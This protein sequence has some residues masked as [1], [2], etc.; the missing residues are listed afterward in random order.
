MINFHDIEQVATKLGT[1]ANAERVIL[2][3]S[4]ARGD[5]REHS[6]VDFMIVAE[7][8]LPRFK[9]SRELYKML[10]PHPF[11]MDIV[12]YTPEEIERGKRTPVSFVSS[13]LQE[14]K[15]LYDR[16]T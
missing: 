7:S 2:F 9:R 10:R 12:V 1:A 14:G 3:G 15:T 8:T 5:A 6:D 13:V 11:G 4:Y 16:R